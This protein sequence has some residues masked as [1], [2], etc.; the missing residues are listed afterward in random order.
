MKMSLDDDE[1]SL[2]TQLKA[3]D[4]RKYMYNKRNI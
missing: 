3:H 4:A 2:M 1:L